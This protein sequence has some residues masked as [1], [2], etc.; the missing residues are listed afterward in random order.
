MQRGFHNDTTPRDDA[1]AAKLAQ[2]TRS[3][4]ST[5]TLADRRVSP[6][7]DL[8]MIRTRRIVLGVATALALSP[9]P[10]A[11][12]QSTATLEQG[13]RTPPDAAK[14]RVWWHWMNGNV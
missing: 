13:F 14:P 3:R 4:S 9:P 11:F 5:S 1:A 6:A 12:A 8:D 10:L 2:A 7:H